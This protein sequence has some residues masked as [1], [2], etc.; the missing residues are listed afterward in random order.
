MSEKLLHQIL[1]KLQVFEGNFRRIDD[2]FQG[3]ED[4]FQGFEDRFQGFEDRFQGFEGRLQ[5]IESNMATKQDIKEIH[6][7]L[8]DI[9]EQVVGNSEKINALENNF[10][11]VFKKVDELDMDMRVVKRAVAN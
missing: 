11:V 7:K 6:Q 8:D 9:T 10:K 3:F 5:N 2:R 1:E 4:R